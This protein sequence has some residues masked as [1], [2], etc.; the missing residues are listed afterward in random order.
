MSMT[1]NNRLAALLADPF[2]S[3]LEKCGRELGG[4]GNVRRMFAQRPIPL[5][6]WEDEHG[7]QL[8]MDVPGLKQDDL[9]LTVENGQLTIRGERKSP[10]CEGECRHDERRFGAF[11][12]V[13]T[14]ADTIDTGS[15]EAVLEDGV[16]SIA[17]SKKP[18]AQPHRVEVKYQSSG[19]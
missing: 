15:I 14:L 13:V 1:I 8:E 7:I 9:E 2:D 3:V 18:E 10:A 16:L 6:L 17:L 19:K 11:E 12:R 5:T 4:G